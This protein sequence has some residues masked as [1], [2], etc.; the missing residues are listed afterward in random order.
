MN[1]ETTF[2]EVKSEHHFEHK[3]ISEYPNHV[4]QETGTNDEA[5]MDTDQLAEVCC[6]CPEGVKMQMML[7]EHLQIEHEHGESF[8]ISF[9]VDFRNFYLLRHNR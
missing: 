7:I 6:L 3:N 4:Y 1:H 8:D 2:H 9:K 5:Q